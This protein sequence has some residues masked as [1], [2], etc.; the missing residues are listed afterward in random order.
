LNYTISEDYKSYFSIINRDID[1]LYSIA[2]K[3]RSLHLDVASEPELHLAK[4]MAEMVEGLVGPLGVAERIRELSK[5]MKREDMAFKIAEEIIFGKFK[6]LSGKYAAEQA[7]RTA[8]AILTEGITVAPI[9]GI[10]KV[11]IKQ[12]LDKTKYIAIYFAGP[13]RS[14]GGTDQALTL[15]IGDYIRKIQG[16]DRYKPTSDE[17]NRFVEEIRIY[18]REVSRFQYHISDS[19]LRNVLENLS[20]EV[21][22]VST[23]PIEVVSYRNLNR[24]ETNQ[25]RAGALRVVNDGII[26]RSRK[27]LSII[28]KL[29]ITGWDWL[30]HIQDFK[31]ASI[32]E[33]KEFMYMEDVIAGRPIFSFPDIK[34]GFRLRYGRA[35]NTGISAVGINPSSMVLLDNFLAI[36]TQIKLEKPGKGGVVMSVDSIEGPIVK[37][38]NGDVV[39]V[40]SEAMARQLKNDVDKILYLGDILISFGD[41]L[42]SNKPLASAG[43]VEEWWVENLNYNIAKNFDGSMEKIAEIT[44]LNTCRLKRILTNPFET[45]P[46]TQEALKLT[47]VLSVPLHPRYTYMW[48]N[49]SPQEFLS[50]RQYFLSVKSLIHDFKGSINLPLDNEITKI[51][52]KLLF[53]FETRDDKLTLTDEMSVLTF[54]LALN[55]ADPLVEDAKNGLEMVQKV[56]CNLVKNKATTFIGSRMGRPEKAKRRETVPPVHLL[57]PVGLEGGTHRNLIE[58]SKK[59]I[60]NI[61][62]VIRKCQSCGIVTHES[63]CPLCGEKT[64]LERKCRNCGTILES[65]ICP[66]CNVKGQFFEKRAVNLKLLLEEATKRLK[67]S[68]PDLVKGVK[69]L[70]SETK[71]P[72]TIEKGI[73]RSKHN[74]FVFKDGTIRFDATNVPLTHFKPAEI[75]VSLEKIVK[76]GYTH[77]VNGEQLTNSNQIC[78]MMIQDIIIPLEGLNYLFNC[79]L[80]LNELLQRI[81]DLPQFYN[82]QDPR[83][84]VGHLIIGL[85]PHTSAGVVGRIIGFTNS[86]VCYAHPLWH[87]A[88]RRDCDGDEDAIMLLLDA[89]L[90]FSKAY[91]PSQIGGLMDAPLLLTPIIN[92]SEVD[93]QVHN[94]DVGKSYPLEFYQK[95]TQEEDPKT[96]AKI[97]DLVSHRLGSQSQYESYNY[98]HP[99][100]NINSGNHESSYK[101]LKTMEDKMN[102]QLL[103][104]KKIA[105]VDAREVARKVITSHL[106]RDIVGNL[107]AFSTQT[108]RCKNCSIKYRRIPLKG[109]CHK[110]G[111][112]LTLTVYKGAIEKYL[113]I[114][115]KVAEDYDLHEYYQQRI[116]MIRDELASMFIEE[117]KVI[118]LQD[119]I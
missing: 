67:T 1:N 119:F 76:L 6:Q 57:F 114:T 27:V 33:I 74:L 68:S 111:G 85:A 75:G 117:K 53:P 54:C 41:F 77:D 15:V 16:L 109:V 49:I 113:D 31:E 18:E 116:K 66:R 92:P 46:T 69:G 28:E 84:L 102:A 95:T 78:E 89:L 96:T 29:G 22:G 19:E 32:D 104:S 4:D 2:T 43:Y 24:I 11:D 13:I 91:L 45:Y 58:A 7:I 12:N 103:L 99:V 23:D 107:R 97:I 100:S 3:A 98:T 25:I 30:R 34:G 42:E 64:N 73:L 50:L 94:M 40:E 36:G 71:T 37:L 5:S 59:G 55:E 56:T 72:E 51:L 115:A 17:I 118:T 88:K 52:E 8:L 14:A 62:I 80:F 90:N 20:V 65:E 47:V 87:A 79:A 39:R 9:Q 112:D 35:R 93:D 48:V 86:N 110:C 10:A 82:T 21:T 108:F 63:K 26:G 105:A 106:I 81:Y 44:K 60:I 70:L 38:R 61:D 101:Q 83:D